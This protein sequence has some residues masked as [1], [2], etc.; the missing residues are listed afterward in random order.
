MGDGAHGQR[1]HLVRRFVVV[2]GKEDIDF[3]T[4]RMR[5]MVEPFVQVTEHKSKTATQLLV[6]VS[7]IFIL[8]YNFIFKHEIRKIDF[9]FINLLYF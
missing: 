8:L 9:L 4:L 6:L 2:G 3:V 7:L 1:G 5:N